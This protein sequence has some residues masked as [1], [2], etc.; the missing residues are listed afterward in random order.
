MQESDLTQITDP[1][2]VR[3]LGWW[4]ELAAAAGKALPD[5]AALDP[6]DIPDLLPHITFWEQLARSAG[7]AR[8]FRCRLAGTALVDV[9][10]YEFTGQMM[11][12][13]HGPKNDQI[14]PEYDWVAE[15]GRPHYVERTLFWQNRDYVRYRRILLPFSHAA[16]G[17][18]D[19]VVFIV[20]VSHFLA[21]DDP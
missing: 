11:G 17:L 14:Q 15:T 6:A 13:F 2:L 12:D 3:A 10:G 21:A 20:N 1:R 18:P 9:H 4:R 19:S 16:A 8:Q 5:R 7:G